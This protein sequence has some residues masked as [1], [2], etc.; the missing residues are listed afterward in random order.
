MQIKLPL[1]DFTGIIDY[2]VKGEGVIEL[3]VDE[4]YNILQ[5]KFELTP[6]NSAPI[7]DSYEVMVR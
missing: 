5:V 7:L 1:N 2:E 3:R 6:G 4:K